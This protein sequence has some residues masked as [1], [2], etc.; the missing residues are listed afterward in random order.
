MSF[1]AHADAKGLLQL[2]KN[3]A[4]KNVVLVH[5]DSEV[6][7]KFQKSV[8][9]SLNINTIMPAN[10]EE[11][12]LDIYKFYYQIDMSVNLFQ[13]LFFLIENNL[14]KS[15]NKAI[16]SEYLPPVRASVKNNGRISLKYMNPLFVVKDSNV[17]IGKKYTVIRNNLVYVLKNES[18]DFRVLFN[19]FL[20]KYYPNMKNFLESLCREKFLSINCNDNKLDIK[21]TYNVKEILEIRKHF[22]SIELIR[23]I[24]CFT[25]IIN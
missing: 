5:G 20:S 22:Q 9:I 1:S 21:W 15:S 4:P 11:A 3:A 8:E 16:R 14:K 7:K 6:M 25:K 19:L 23:Y 24:E 10:L 13:K 2:I 18:V 17:S 12:Y